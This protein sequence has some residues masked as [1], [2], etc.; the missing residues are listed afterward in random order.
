MFFVIG[1]R[2]WVQFNDGMA[3]LT[4]PPVCLMY[5]PSPSAFLANRFANKRLA[6]GQ[7]WLARCI[8][9]ACGRQ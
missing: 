8:H 1:T 3:V 9:E 4:L 5:R 7:H 2:H 6:D